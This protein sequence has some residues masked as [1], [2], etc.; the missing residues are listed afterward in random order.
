MHLQS[1]SRETCY[2]I[3]PLVSLITF[4]D[5]S[6]YFNPF[7]KI[8][9]FLVCLCSSYWCLFQEIPPQ[10][11]II[12]F[13]FAPRKKIKMALYW[14]LRLPLPIYQYTTSERYLPCFWSQKDSYSSL[15]FRN[16]THFLKVKICFSSW[17]TKGNS[18]SFLCSWSSLIP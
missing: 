6:H 17:P 8:H 16:S 5:V 18:C 4:H 14:L 1:I 7:P 11:Q 2:F 15:V 10:L 13:F 9:S 3:F 12:K